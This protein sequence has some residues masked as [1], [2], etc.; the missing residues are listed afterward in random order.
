LKPETPF[1]ALLAPELASSAIGT[2]PANPYVLIALCVKAEVPVVLILG[3]FFVAVS[4]SWKLSNQ[5]EQWC[6]NYPPAEACIQNYGLE[7][8]VP[9]T[10]QS[11]PGWKF[12]T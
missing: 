5:T 9:A 12:S 3:V 7:L 6:K 11:E 10:R 2:I 4:P 8:R 1:P